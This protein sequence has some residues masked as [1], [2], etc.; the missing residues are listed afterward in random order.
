M[1][2][3]KA[4][5]IAQGYSQEFGIDYEVFASVAKMTTVGGLL[6]VAIVKRWKSYQIDVSVHSC[7]VI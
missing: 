3:Y 7:M 1:E 5:P 4:G 2:R 6:A